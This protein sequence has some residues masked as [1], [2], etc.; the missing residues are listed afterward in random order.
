MMTPT[1]IF[2]CFVVFMGWGLSSFI[3]G[4]IGRDVPHQSALVCNMLGAFLVNAV[5]FILNRGINFSFS[6]Y[7][8]GAILSGTL[9][10]VADLCYY[11]LSKAGMPVSVLGPVTSLYIIVPILLGALFLKEALTLR[12]LVGI[13]FGLAA[14]WLLSAEEGGTKIEQSKNHV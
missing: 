11:R 4:L 6:S 3:M 1:N 8:L 12:K 13:A 7:H 14:L 5:W 2:Y 9:F 10:T